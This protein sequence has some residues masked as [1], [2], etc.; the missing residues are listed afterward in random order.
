[1]ETAWLENFLTSSGNDGGTFC[2]VVDV[3]HE[4]EVLFQSACGLA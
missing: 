4:G 2:G 3:R 1:M